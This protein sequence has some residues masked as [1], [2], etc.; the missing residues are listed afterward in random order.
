METLNTV[1]REMAQLV[2]TIGASVVRVEARKRQAASG[3]VMNTDGVIVTSNHVVTRDENIRIGLPDGN[4]VDA[5]VI[6]RDPGTDLAVL[7]TEATNLKTPT[8]A[9]TDTAQVGNLVLAVGR[10]G[11]R[12]QAT[13][14]V[15]SALGDAWQVMGGGKIDVFLRTDVV[16]YPGFSG[17][18]LVA[19]NGNILGLNTSALMRGESLTIPTETIQRVANALLKDGHVKRGYLGITAQTVRLPQAAADDAGQAT[20]LLIASVEQGSP[21]ESGGILLGDVIVMVGEN[22]TR[23]ME[24]LLA[25]LAGGM[26]GET[27]TVK[28]LRGGAMIDISV[29]IGERG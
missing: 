25:M 7:K 14:G 15:V 9:N 5:S 17:G 18:P 3:I 27:V 4:T 29:T 24:E 6:G 20:G 22:R 16:M 26:V 13:L 2:E 28:V 12:L 1:S 21:A 8:W 19:A 11:N 23:S 10:P